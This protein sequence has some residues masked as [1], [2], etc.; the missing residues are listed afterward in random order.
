M[1]LLQRKEL[2]RAA[3]LLREA[4]EF[5]PQQATAFQENLRDLERDF[6]QIGGQ[7]FPS[8]TRL[9]A[10]CDEVA[11]LHKVAKPLADLA[12]KCAKCGQDV[13]KLRNQIERHPEPVLSATARC[14]KWLTELSL[15]VSRV[16]RVE[17]LASESFRSG[18]GRL[19]WIGGAIVLHEN[20]LV[21]LAESAELIDTVGRGSDTA[22]LE[23]SLDGLRQ[24]FKDPGPDAA[25]LDELERHTA[26][27]R[28]I[29]NTP[30]PEPPPPP[31]GLREIQQIMIEISRWKPA[32][33]DCSSVVAELNSRLQQLDREDKYHLPEI[34]SLRRDV[35]D[36]RDDLR[37]RAATLRDNMLRTLSETVAYFVTAC[38]NDHELADRVDRLRK[39]V[40]QQPIEPLA[41]EDWKRQHDK[42]EE[43]FDGLAQTKI[44]E[45]E[46]YLEER[47]RDLQAALSAL[48][49]GNLR[50]QTRQLLRLELGKLEQAKAAR[51][52]R[53][54]LGA[55]RSVAEVQSQSA[56]LERQAQAD[57]E[58]YGKEKAQA[59]EKLREL[60]EAAR[61]AGVAKPVIG[62]LQESSGGGLDDCYTEV[63]KLVSELNAAE[64]RFLD[65]C[66]R[67]NAENYS[68]CNLAHTIL[69]QAV[70]AKPMPALPARPVSTAQP[71]AAARLRLEWADLRQSYESRLEQ[72]NQAVQEAICQMKRQL[73]NL[74]AG[75]QE[76]ALEAQGLLD[77]I[78]TGAYLDEQDLLQRVSGLNDL[79]ARC[80]DF[81]RRLDRDRQEADDKHAEMRRRWRDFAERDLRKYFP[82]HAARVT[83]LLMGA[84]DQRD[85][86]AR[87]RQLEEAAELLNY[88]EAAARRV[89][90][91]DISAAC[92]KLRLRLPR[93]SG[94]KRQEIEAVLSLVSE[95]GGYPTSD[96]RRRLFRL[97]EER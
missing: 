86:R 1:G 83:A 71:V 24:R 38:G 49:E 13:Q 64:A 89:A 46:R 76:D 30:K 6:Q 57:L 53:A 72:Q 8:A 51:G 22:A 21:R 66:S 68:Y 45:L 58:L 31:E 25:W 19:L 17:D 48:D 94:A 65:E 56:V 87:A 20:A 63:R 35:R 5:G 18:Q 37:T 62:E 42:T 97:A 2:E 36:F 91:T 10:F 92:C 23:N 93:T 27:V 90:V 52:R 79:M 44:R 11:E 43:Y 41:L 80:D 15:I 33:P 50:D 14:D 3:G 7:W 39:A 82:E 60:E 59:L 81:F 85:C 55:L 12:Q 73:G 75:R 74:P 28:Q 70:G 88:L 4:R 26:P 84:K 54:I 32:L 47:V 78:A 40:G 9:K 95:T 69:Q 77:D 61:I 16:M 29:A 96:A 34:D 67:Q